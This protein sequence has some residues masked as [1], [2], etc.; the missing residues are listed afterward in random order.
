MNKTP[1]VVLIFL[2]AIVS[3][4]FNYLTISPWIVIKYKDIIF[5]E[6]SKENFKE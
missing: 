5:E 4:V 2:N 1:Y 3:Y 6:Y